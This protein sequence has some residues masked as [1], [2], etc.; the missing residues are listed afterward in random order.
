MVPDPD[1]PLGK[2]FARL[3]EWMPLA[4][5]EQAID[6]YFKGERSKAELADRP[7]ASQD[8]E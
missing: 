6:A 8:D 2:L 5:Y 4:E 3:G 7:R 1:T